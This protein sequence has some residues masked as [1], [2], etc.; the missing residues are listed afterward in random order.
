MLIFE[1]FYSEM[2]EFESVYP[3]QYVKLQNRLVNCRL[4]DTFISN[5]YEMEK[6]RAFFETIYSN[7]R[8]TFCVIGDQGK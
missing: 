1:R 7:L 2:N 5:N 8:W 4:F 6:N 3:I